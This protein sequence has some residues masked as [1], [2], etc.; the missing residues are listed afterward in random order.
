MFDFLA[1]KTRAAQRSVRWFL[2]VAVAQ[3]VTAVTT[4]LVVGYLLMFPI[5]LMY[6]GEDRGHTRRRRHSV[7]FSKL[8][9]AFDSSTP[10]DIKPCY[11]MKILWYTSLGGIAA[12]G[13]CV[14]AATIYERRRIEQ[15]GGWA[16]G[17]ALGG[18]HV[19]EPINASDRKIVNV[20]EELAIAYQTTPPSVLVLDAEP[21]INAFAA[22]LNPANSILCVTG[23]AIEHLSREELQALVAHEFS[24]LVN[25]DTKFGTQ[26]TAILYGLNGIYVV[27]SK[28]ISDGMRTSEYRE[29]ASGW[30][31]AIVGVSI[32][33]FG[34]AGTWSASLLSLAFCRSREQLA[35]AEAVDK[36]RNPLALARALRKITGHRKQGRLMHPSAP[37]VAPMLFMGRS[38]HGGWLST[39]P[40][41]ADRLIAIDP[42]G[43]HDP[44]HQKPAGVRIKNEGSQTADV[45]HALLGDDVVDATPAASTEHSRWDQLIESA[46]GLDTVY[47]TIP[48]PFLQ[49]VGFHT[50]LPLTTTLLLGV[51]DLEVPYAETRGQLSQAFDDLTPIARFAMLVK[52]HDEVSALSASDRK[53]LV[54]MLDRIETSFAA[55]DWCRHGW[56]WLLRQAVN[57]ESEASESRSIS[58]QELAGSMCVVLSVICVCDDE[59]GMSDYEFL[60]GWTALGLGEASR[61]PADELDWRTFVAAID[62]LRHSPPH[63]K[64]T[65][66]VSIA[67][68]VSGDALVSPEESVLVQ[69]ITHSLQSVTARLT[70]TV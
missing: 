43:D 51:D 48:D 14:L 39:H 59:T 10:A 66:M 56:S 61:I 28:L 13:G 46:G 64:Q 20:V 41:V 34:L 63:V 33:P 49:M 60:R 50:T 58:H 68:T 36:T 45:L 69:V 67:N 11:P 6:C 52:I 7:S 19:D 1:R 21:A 30:M 5:V 23:G 32:L 27:A 65:L 38:C 15:E 3:A 70:P 26:L 40:A 25:Q 47:A 8:Q 18:R 31:Q 53:S 42:Q 35:D 37:I 57:G 17:I 55:D 2:M 29:D 12:V 4:G 22:G 9:L 24:H 62:V 16:L 54:Q 44:I